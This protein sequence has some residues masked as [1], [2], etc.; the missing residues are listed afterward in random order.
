MAVNDVY[1]L[2]VI[3]QVNIF[4]SDLTMEFQDMATCIINVYLT[5]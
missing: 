3:R 2:G 5:I 4:R 1:P